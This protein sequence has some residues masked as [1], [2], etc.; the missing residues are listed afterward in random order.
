MENTRLAVVVI[1]LVIVLGIGV[2]ASRLIKDSTDF[3]LAG[4]RLGLLMATATLA[5]THFGGGFVMGSSADGHVFGISGLYY[6]VGTGLGLIALGLVAAKR[7]RKL[8]LYTITD[9]LEMRYQSKLVRVL[10][11]LLSVVAIV[12]IVAAQVGATEGALTILGIA[13]GTGAI[14]ATL[15][16]ISYTAFAGMWGVTF[17]DAIQIIIIMFALP[18][19]AYLGVQH[20]GGWEA[21]RATIAAMD[22]AGGAETYFS[23]GGRGLGVAIAVILP[24]IMYDMIGQDF[25]QRLFSAK[26][27]NTARNAAILSGLVLV[28]FGVFPAVAG[29]AARAIFG[30]L[31]VARSALPMLITQVL[32]VGIGAIVVAAIMAAVMS[33]ADS[34][35]IAGTSHV[36]NDFYIKL[37]NPEIAKDTKKV[38]ALSRIWTVILGGLALAMALIMPGIISVLIFSYTMY[39]SGVFVPVVLGLLWK[40]GTKEGAIAGII[41]GSLVGLASTG[42]VGLISIGNWPAII[43]GGTASLILYVGVSLATKPVDFVLEE[44]E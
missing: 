13:P 9:Y 29:M 14:I 36:T 16:F 5:A 37:I 28:A 21:M 2:Y 10:G 38:L 8:K 30:E 20:A 15:L 35:L 7:L 34:L 42:Q 41:G 26:D 27:E 18:V 22:V 19:V 43:I 40:R 31:E 39:A 1:Y 4:R 12:G 24:V 11:A 3:L 23:L 32:P 6:A 33:T 44:L 25:Y 17:T